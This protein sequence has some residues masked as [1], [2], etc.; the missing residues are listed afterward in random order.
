LKISLV[1][2]DE[3]DVLLWRKPIV[4]ALAAKGLEVLVISPGGKGGE[5][6]E[7]M[8]CRRIR[9]GL[10]RN[11]LFPV[12]EL[13]SIWEL[14]WIYRRW[15]PDLT[16]HF[17]IKPN[18]YGFIS[19]RLAKVPVSVATV[20]GLGF[21]WITSRPGFRISRYFLKFIYRKVLAHTDCTIFLNNDDRRMLGGPNDVVLP[22]EGVDLQRFSPMAVPVETIK[23]LRDS[24]GLLDNQ[25]VVIMVG[26]MLWHKG[27]AEYV[28]CAKI[29]RKK[30]TN[31]RFYLIG[32]IDRLNPAHIDESVI[33]KWELQ[34]NIA[35]LGQ[36]EDIRDLMALADL[37]VLPSY[38][39]GLPTVLAEGAA[40]G[41]PL[42]A[43]D[44]PGCRDVIEDGSNG[45]LV[46]ARDPIALSVAIDKILS[47]AELRLRFQAASRSIA[48][49]KFSSQTIQ[50]TIM[51]IYMALLRS[52][53][54]LT[55]KPDIEVQMR[56][57]GNV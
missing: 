53:G 21:L 54:R 57:P 41:M 27:V 20:T 8:G 28:E 40:M 5:L 16:H 55:G 56:T 46:P 25:P 17:S 44:V 13:F 49:K 52:T 6:L 26:R 34:G 36:R 2:P 14:F 12:T 50:Q 18:I 22:G 4:Q 51:G 7:H 32:P 23:R 33:N 48:E 19:A 15:K 31:C 35:Y 24:L 47:D 9:W 3:K 11:G 29:L 42:V 45:F 37:L 43:T 38:R 1:V 10:K 39:E 30:H